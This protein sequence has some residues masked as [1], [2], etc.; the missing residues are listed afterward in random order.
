MSGYPKSQTDPVP[1]DAPA[2][3][4]RPVS[5]LSFEEI[6]ELV[7]RGHALRA[8]Y[9]AQAGKNFWQTWL[10]VWRR[11]GRLTTPHTAQTA[12]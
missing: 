1:V 12:R 11:P 8:A 5:Q 2:V 10:S 3:Y 9:I 7:A 4:G 6:D